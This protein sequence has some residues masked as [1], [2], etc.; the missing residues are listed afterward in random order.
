M[1][2]GKFDK[3][4]IEIK[5]GDIVH[6]R[7]KKC[8]LSGKGIVYL[9]LTDGLSP[10]PFRIKDTRP[11]KNNGRIYPWYDDAVYRICSNSEE[12]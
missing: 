10:E 4:G 7:C 3:T 1:S 5:V 8:A 6:F 9:D 12:G 2:T 11:N